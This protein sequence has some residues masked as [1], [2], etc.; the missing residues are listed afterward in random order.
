MKLFCALLLITA[1]T[2]AQD[3][4]PDPKALLSDAIL[5][6]RAQKDRVATVH[7]RHGRPQ[8]QAGGFGFGGAV[9]IVVSGPGGAKGKPYEGTAQIW[10]DPSGATVVTSPG[11]KLPAF[12]LY[13]SRDGSAVRQITYGDGD[14]AINMEMLQH[15]LVSL[16]DPDRFMRHVLAARGQL[17]VTVDPTTGAATFTGSID[18][19][20][21]EAIPQKLPPGV[22][23]AAVQQMMGMFPQNL[24]LEAKATF[25]VTKDGRFKTAAITF[26]RND[27]NQEM[28]RRWKN[29]KGARVV[30]GGFGGQAPPPQGGQGGGGAPPPPKP[31]G[32]DAQKDGEKKKADEK[33]IEGGTTTYT[34]TFENAEPSDAAKGFKREVARLAGG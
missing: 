12:K 10:R 33:P 18:P 5:H 29:K 23:A 31:G 28:L 14:G 30:I 1:A 25:V 7:I 16:L 22:P 32:D 26:T 20:I 21:A 27:P 17:Q 34:L 15:E 11:G 9:Q 13:V 24:L 8:G 19:K 4:A 2:R 6:Y 3:D